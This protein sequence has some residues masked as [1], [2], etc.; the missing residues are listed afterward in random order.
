MYRKTFAAVAAAL[1]FGAAQAADATFDLTQ[2]VA[3]G[4][5]LYGTVSLTQDGA[6]VD[7]LVDL[8][9]GF[10]FVKTG[11][12][13]SFTFNIVGA[14]GYS[15]TNID[16]SQF[17]W[18]T[19]ASNPSF[20]SYTDGLEC[21]VC[22]NGGAGAI[23]PPLSFTVT[24][25]T[26]ANFQ[27]NAAGYLFSADIVGQGLTGAVAAVPE[28]ESYALMLAGLGAVGFIARRRKQQA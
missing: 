4:N 13:D 25:V 1:S 23:N 8:V 7:V 2:S 21:L 5:G 16:P 26:V 27:K 11:N 22:S 9:S 28:P 15:V 19:P 20:G 18:F 14:S 17:S 3:F 12:H 24:G 10:Q 6:D